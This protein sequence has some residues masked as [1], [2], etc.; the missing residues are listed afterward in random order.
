MFTYEF[1]GYFVSVLIGV[2]LGL[3]GGG[4]SILAVPM[5]TYLFMIEEKSATAY[6]L[7]IVG[8][9]ALVGGLQKLLKGKVHLPTIAYFGIPA[10]VG[11]SLMRFFVVPNIPTHLFSIGDFEVTRRLLMLG[12][13]A[14]LMIPA[15]MFM[16]K[17]DKAVSDDSI[18][19]NTTNRFLMIIQ[20]LLVGGITGLVG[21]GGGFLIIPAIMALA[22]L[23]MKT[24]VSTSLIIVMLNSF[25]GFFIGDAF[26]QSIDWNFLFKITGL[27]LIGIFVGMGLGNYIDGKKLKKGFG[28]FIVAMAA[29][30]FY[31]EIFVKH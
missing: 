28:Y 11:I 18:A 10:V 15:A 6:S 4:G 20:G 2:S 30:I 9:T 23:D 3:I 26:R 22:K 31:M 7:F 8:S 14:F 5:L 16:L 29:F 25:S 12:L 13:F 21:A 17:K 1:I 19:L 27:A 24:A